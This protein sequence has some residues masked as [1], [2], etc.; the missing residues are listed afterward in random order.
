MQILIVDNNKDIA[1]I[2]QEIVAD[3]L[4]C[5]VD[6]AHGGRG[7]LAKLKKYNYDV[8][9]LDVMMPDLN[10]VEVCQKMSQDDRLPKVPVILISALPLSSVIN[11]QEEMKR[12][13]IIKGVLEKP[14]DYDELLYKIREVVGG[15]EKKATS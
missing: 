9:V 8:M 15:K 7:A 13:G 10:G 14:F 1:E 2:I 5:R 11:S 6:V 4:K 3:E 12:L